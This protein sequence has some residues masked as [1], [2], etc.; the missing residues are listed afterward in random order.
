MNT[1]NA[2]SSNNLPVVHA[3]AELSHEDVCEISGG[4]LKAYQ[5]AAIGVGAVFFGGALLAGGLLVAG[6]VAI[7]GG[8]GTTGIGAWGISL[9]S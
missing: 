1:F 5:V 4:R 3:M 7:V 9:G 8:A 2:K 6:G